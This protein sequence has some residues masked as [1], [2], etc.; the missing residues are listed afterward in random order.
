M[1]NNH[2]KNG[3]IFNTCHGGTRA[4]V[5]TGRSEHVERDHGRAR[6]QAPDALVREAL[7]WR[8]AEGEESGDGPL[9]RRWPHAR[10]NHSPLRRCE[11]EGRRLSPRAPLG[12]FGPGGCVGD[13]DHIYPIGQSLV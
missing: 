9:S 11:L 13:F 6:I 4:A 5:G 3:T 2:S 12:R 8:L 10:Q 1:Q 7:H